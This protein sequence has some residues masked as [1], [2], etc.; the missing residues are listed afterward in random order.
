MNELPRKPLLV[1]NTVAKSLLGVG[2]TK[3]WAL[4]KAGQV[5]LVPVGNTKMVRYASLERL[6]SPQGAT[7]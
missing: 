1:S 4:V 5:E 3:Y 6:A 2:N 7:E